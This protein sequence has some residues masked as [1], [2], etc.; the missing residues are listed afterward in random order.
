MLRAKRALITGI[1]GQD[2]SYLSELLLKQGYDV[3]GVELK[4]SPT[5]TSPNLSNLNDKVQLYAG[6]VC[7]EDFVQAV[8]KSWKPNE[9][10]HLAAKTIVS[11]D[12][13]AERDTLLQNIT[14]THLLLSASKEHMPESRFF[15]AATSEIFGAPTT[16]PQEI[17]MPFLPRSIYGI[18]KLSSV[19]L[20]RYYRN[21]HNYFAATGVLYNHES[22]RRGPHF[23]TQKIATA[24]ARIKLGLQ[25]DVVLGNLDA[26]RD[27]GHANDFV[28]GF[29]LQLQQKEPSE[30][31]F[32]TGT[33]HT[34]RDFTER[35]FRR[36]GL[37]YNNYVVVS[38]EFF[39]RLEPVPLVG[40]NSATKKLLGWTLAHSF[41]EIV[42][43]MVDAAMAR[44]LSEL[45]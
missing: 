40:D 4:T 15:F 11:Y 8:L 26:K 35:A 18:S 42:N 16:H 9:I 27:W 39:R 44:S 12:P 21:Q 32:S 45:K 24:A 2:G 29:W 34:V 5:L 1:A 41:D 30:L 10:Y 7:D 17:E 3:A 20:V 28:R 36:V 14:G 22:P 19:H 6:D 33:T 31:I 37:D 43:E 13:D 25:A 38:K 23:V